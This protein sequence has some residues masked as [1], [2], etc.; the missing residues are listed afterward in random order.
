MRVSMADGAGSFDRNRAVCLLQEATRLIADTERSVPS[1]NRNSIT[2]TQTT[3]QPTQQHSSNTQF[4]MAS[5]STGVNNTNRVLGNFRN[6]FAPYGNS[7]YKSTSSSQQ[8]ANPPKNRKK[9]NAA[10]YRRET[11]THTFCCLADLEQCAPPSIKMKENLQKAGLGQKKICFH[12]K[13]SAIDVKTKLEDVFPKLSKSGG[14]DILRRGQQTSELVLIHPPHSGY[15]VPFL[16]DEGGL[17]QAVAFIRPIQNNLDMSPLAT[18]EP[19]E[20]SL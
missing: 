16:R 6:L 9:Q 5:T 1:T 8:L 3:S 12:W 7:N 2:L 15:N 13:A 20:V 11:W 14:F 19:T 4:N 18:M 17:G 10:F